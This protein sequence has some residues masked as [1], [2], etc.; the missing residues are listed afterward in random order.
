MSEPTSP[1]EHENMLHVNGIDMFY[2][3]KGA[4]YPL[5]LLHG[6]TGTHNSWDQHI[7]LLST[8]YEIIIPDLRGHG[9]STNPINKLEYHQMADDIAMFINDLK[10]NQPLL[11]GW[12]DGGQIA[13]ELAIRHTN[14]VRGFA[15][16]AIIHK[17]FEEYKQSVSYI[18]FPAPGEVDIEKIKASFP[19]WVEDLNRWHQ[20]S[21]DH[22]IN[23]LHQ[24][25]FLWY[26][27]FNYPAEILKQVDCPILLMLGD[28][29]DAIPV[30]HMVDLYHA[31][32]NAGLAVIPF[33][34]H[35]VYRYRLE[36]FCRLIID[37][38]DRVLAGEFTS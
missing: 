14:L 4:G 23:L 24:I 9:R 20:Q 25:S 11:C 8:R 10:L 22:W 18:G 7:H 3:R 32:P 31:L 35:L 12:S 33:G 34:R 2:T 37:Y 28:R 15:V 1:N 16:G 13:L 5:I 30:E 17:L 36:I 21:E 6:G 29:D 19:E 26:T 38:F 27:E